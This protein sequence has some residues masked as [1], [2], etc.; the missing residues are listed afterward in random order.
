MSTAKKI[1]IH[2]LSQSERILLAEEL[3]DSIAED[4]DTLEVTA[5]QKKI[6]EDRLAAYRASPNEGSSWEDVKKEMQ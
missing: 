6:L 5:S 2:E 4:Q 3:W 1:D